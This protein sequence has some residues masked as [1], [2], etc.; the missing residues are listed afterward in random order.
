MAEKP[1]KNLEVGILEGLAWTP[2]AREN[3]LE[4]V[5]KFVSDEAQ[6]AIV[7]YLSKKGTEASGCPFAAF[8]GYRGYDRSRAHSSPGTDLHHQW[9]AAYCPGWASVAL[10]CAVACIGLDRFFGFSSAWMRFLAT[11]LQIRNALQA[12]QLD[13]EMH[14]AARQ[15][16]PPTDEQVQELLARCKAFLVQVNTYVEQEMAAWMKEFQA[17]LQ[18]IDDSARTQAE[19][20]KLGGVTVVVTN[21]E[22][23]SNGWELSIDG[24][25]RK[26]YTGKTAA[27]RDLLP[28][29]H[30]LRV[31]G[32]RNGR[33]VQAEQVVVIPAGDDDAD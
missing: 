18:Q 31:E 19:A 26:R 21:G 17:A 9:H 5:C 7:W 20:A 1:G 6:R 25:S 4:Q 10:V 23:C 24:G 2:E 16:A 13:W 15:G 27:L 29:I 33:E 30:T 22:Q 3:S 32:T 28:G 11:E 14:K 12:F 8:V